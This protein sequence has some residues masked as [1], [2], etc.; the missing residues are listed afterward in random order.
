MICRERRAS[1][2]HQSDKRRYRLLIDCGVA[3]SLSA[4]RSLTGRDASCRPRSGRPAQ[5]HRERL[6]LAG[7]R[8]RPEKRE[9]LRGALGGSYGIKPTRAR[10][11]AW[12]ASPLGTLAHV[13]CLTRSVADAALALTI[14]AAPDIR[15]VYAWT[16]PAPD[17]RIG[18]DE[19]VS[20]M[21]VAYSRR[22]GYAT[23]I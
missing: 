9:G 4:Q 21:K 5:W 6:L 1:H 10:V 23:R 18:L 12:P 16:S 15:D 19:G 3:C 17:F 7:S 11:P 14:M 13:G 20:G 22:L 2:H 8:G